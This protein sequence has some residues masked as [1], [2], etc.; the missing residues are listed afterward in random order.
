ML[1]K[2]FD[3]TLKVNMYVHKKEIWLRKKL[4]RT[5]LTALTYLRE[6]ETEI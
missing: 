6:L 2:H 4:R 1:N 3:V 5:F